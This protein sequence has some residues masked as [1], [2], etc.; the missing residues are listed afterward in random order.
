MAKRYSSM[1][2]RIIANS[3][4]SPE[5]F[6]QDPDTGEVSPCWEWTGKTIAS[7]N[8]TGRRYPV[9]TVKVNGKVRNV[10]VHRLVLVEFKGVRMTKVHVGAH[11]CNYT[12]CVNPEHLRRDTG[13]GNMRQCVREGRHNS[14]PAND[15]EHLGAVA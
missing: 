5:H 9:L 14:N 6:Y 10:R 2:E 15:F 1:Q 4:L 3:V 8:G 11:R 7:R 13:S 12:F